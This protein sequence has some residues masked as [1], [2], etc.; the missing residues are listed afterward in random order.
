NKDSKAFSRSSNVVISAA[1]LC[2]LARGYSDR[3]AAFPPRRSGGKIEQSMNRGDLGMNAHLHHADC[4]CFSRLSRRG[5]LGL[6]LAAA[7]TKA[8]PAL[9]DYGNYQAMLFN[10]IDPRF[11]NTTF[12]YMAGRGLKDQY[13]HF[14][15]AGGPIGAVAP[16]FADWR[17]TWW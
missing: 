7:V 16:V 8:F 4:G 17:K 13:S 6:G 14:V 5:I 10:C 11:T 3:P 9:A 2:R 15:L 12:T 1:P